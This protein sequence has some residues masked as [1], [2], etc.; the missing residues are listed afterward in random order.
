MPPIWRCQNETSEIHR[1]KGLD[2]TSQTTCGA[3]TIY[4]KPMRKGIIHLQ[5]SMPSLGF[6]P[7]SYGTAAIG[8]GPR[9]FQPHSSDKEDTLTGSPLPSSYRTSAANRKKFELR[10]I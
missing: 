2:P 5:I 6:K 1:D 7:R 4:S 10:Q 3:M 9:N 8:D